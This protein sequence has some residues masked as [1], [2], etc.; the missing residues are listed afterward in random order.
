MELL[1][2]LDGY[3]TYIAAAGAL[4]LAWYYYTQGDTSHA[5]EMVTFAMALFGL[6]SAINKPVEVKPTEPK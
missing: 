2:K 4:A 1:S 6:R 5:L 3:K